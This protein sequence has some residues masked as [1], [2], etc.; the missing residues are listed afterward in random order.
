[1][2]GH[3]KETQGQKCFMSFSVLFRLAFRDRT[4]CTVLPKTG[5]RLHQITCSPMLQDS[6]KKFFAFYKNDEFSDYLN[7][8]QLLKKVSASWG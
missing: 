2:K 4:E 6:K 8:C 7:Q 3:R 5:E 1:M